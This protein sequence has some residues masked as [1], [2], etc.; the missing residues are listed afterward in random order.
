MTFNLPASGPDSIAARQ[1]QLYAARHL[2]VPRLDV[3]KLQASVRRPGGTIRDDSRQGS[4]VRERVVLASDICDP[5]VDLIVT[6]A[7]MCV[8]PD[9]RVMGW[10]LELRRWDERFGKWQPPPNKVCG[11]LA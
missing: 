3:T 9:S 4:G 10:L 8:L 2:D 11:V 7:M 1:A 6:R 5:K